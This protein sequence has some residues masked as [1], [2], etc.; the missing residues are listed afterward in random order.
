LYLKH[1]S[2]DGVT[3]K[4]AVLQ[5]LWARY[6]ESVSDD[7]PLVFGL[8]I[9]HPQIGSIEEFDIFEVMLRNVELGIADFTPAFVGIQRHQS[10]DTDDDGLT[11]VT[12]TAPNEKHIL[13][14]RNILW[15]AGVANRSSFAAAKAETIM[16]TLVKYN[17]T[18]F[19]TVANGRQRE[20]NLATA[21]DVAITIAADGARGNTLSLAFM[22]ANLLTVLQKI[23]EQGG[24]DFS[25]QWQG[26]TAWTFEFHPGQLGSDK[27]TGTDRVVFSTTPGNNTMARPRLIYTG[28]GATVAISGGKGEGLARQIEPVNG[29]DY[30]A[31]YDIETFVDARN[32]STAAG[33]IFR[34]GLRLEEVRPRE[35]LQFEVLQTANQF[36]SPVAV[37]GRKTYRAGDLVLATYGGERVRKIDAIEVNWSAPERGDAFTVSVTTREVPGA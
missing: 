33:L 35:A 6:T 17:A 20:G 12:F 2:R 31:D 14:W 1:F 26:G 34:G 16:K 36:Y 5:P 10:I 13:S 28:A 27:S 37:I 3:V 8:D 4:N 21:M 24:G 18:S 19:A 22:G 11:V 15:Y 29:P 30:A 23:S 9:D 32:E 7:K 25:F